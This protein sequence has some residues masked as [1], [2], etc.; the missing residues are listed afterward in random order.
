ME[1]ERPQS[2]RAYGRSREV[3][4]KMC[5]ASTAGSFTAGALARLKDVRMRV[6]RIAVS[7]MPFEVIMGRGSLGI[8]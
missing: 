3:R 1:R 6:N 7:W 2:P 5:S 8:A 4:R